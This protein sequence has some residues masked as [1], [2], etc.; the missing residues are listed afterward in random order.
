MEIRNPAYA[1]VPATE[2]MK[3]QGF[4][5]LDEGSTVRIAFLNNQK[6]NTTELLAGIEE[7]LG[8]RYQVESRNFWKGDAAHP[9]PSDVIAGINEY[10]DVAVLAT[11]D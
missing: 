1:R 9:A 4:P 11:A 3:A 8:R 7:R 10:A 5:R 6:P 2:G